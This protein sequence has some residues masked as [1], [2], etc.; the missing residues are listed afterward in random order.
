MK[1]IKG[2]GRGGSRLGAG[3]KKGSKKTNYTATFYARC[4]EKE[5]ELLKKYLE[6]LRKK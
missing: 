6:E 2:S 5:K 3:R 4:T 1:Y